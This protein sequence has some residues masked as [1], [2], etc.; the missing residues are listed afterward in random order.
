MNYLSVEITNF[1]GPA[2]Q[3]VEV[4]LAFNVRWEGSIFVVAN[5]SIQLTKPML[6]IF[7]YVS[8]IG[9]FMND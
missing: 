9:S 7:G 3:L 1:F 6:F 4:L 5:V 2:K 8:L